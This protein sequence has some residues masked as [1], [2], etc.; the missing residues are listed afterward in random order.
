MQQRSAYKLK[1]V[2]PN[3]YQM[4]S[5]TFETII[6]VFVHPLWT[7]AVYESENEI[8]IVITKDK[9]PIE[10]FLFT[11]CFR[12]FVMN[13]MNQTIEEIENSCHN[14]EL[15]RTDKKM[16]ASRL[17]D[18]SG[19]LYIKQDKTWFIL[20]KFW[21]GLSAKKTCNLIQPSIKNAFKHFDCDTK[22]SKTAI[23]R[24]GRRV[25]DSFCSGDLIF[26]DDF[27]T[28]DKNIWEHAQTLEGGGNNEFQW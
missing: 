23:M 5:K 1:V 26:E 12:E 18:D 7:P 4:V 13:V 16:V 27:D 17:Q 19:A 8:A 2:L 14:P 28:L 24:N 10:F 3:H 9:I 6:R 20:G 15:Q 21:D 11:T 25:L 22:R